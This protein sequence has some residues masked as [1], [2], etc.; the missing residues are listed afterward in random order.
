MNMKAIVNNEAAGILEEKKTLMERFDQL[1][2]EILINGD[3]IIT[4]RLS[5]EKV[6]KQ[7][8]DN[9]VELVRNL[10]ILGQTIQLLK[11]TGRLSDNGPSGDFSGEVMGK[12]LDKVRHKKSSIA[13][14]VQKVS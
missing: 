14:I 8:T 12:I 4:R 6:E 11:K 9:Q 2:Q 3:D 1:A 5:G 10:K 13:N 7:E